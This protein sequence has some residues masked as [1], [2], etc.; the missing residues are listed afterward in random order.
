MIPWLLNLKC[1]RQGRSKTL[2]ILPFC[3]SSHPTPKIPF[4]RLKAGLGKQT[5]KNQ[6][7][8]TKTNKNQQKPTKTNKNQQKPTKTNK[9][10]Q[11]PT[12]TDLLIPSTLLSNKD[13]FKSHKKPTS[14]YIRER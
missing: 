7:K 8:P 14:Y 11:K 6:Q 5:N 10:Q 13:L 2:N 1:S 4:S 12:K 3:T 9:N